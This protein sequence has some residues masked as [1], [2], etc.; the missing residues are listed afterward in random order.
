MSDDRDRFN[1]I[2]AIAINPA[3]YEEEAIAALRKARELVKQN[4][5]LAHPAAPSP[6]SPPSE[7]HFKVM[8]INIPTDWLG[9]VAE[10]LFKKADGLGLNSKIEYDFSTIPSGLDVRADGI[11]QACNA[12]ERHVTWLIDYMNSRLPQPQI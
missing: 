8:I 7:Y 4:R 3:T 6:K 2:I 9:V 1:K 5:V 10:N 12:F 11:K